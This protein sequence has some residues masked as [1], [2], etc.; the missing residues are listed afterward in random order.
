MN[1]LER[2][3]VLT[4]LIDRMREHESWCGETHIQKATY[5]LQTLLGV[6]ID[7]P[8]IMYKY[9]PF[10][11]DLRDEMVAMRADGHLGWEI[12]APYGPRYVSTPAA[13][14]M[15]AR[16]PQTLESYQSRIEFAAEKLGSKGV[17]ELEQLATALF[18]TVNPEALAKQ[19]G[20]MDR[21]QTLM[22]LK[23][24]IPYAAARQAIDEMDEII[25]AAKLQGLAALPALDAATAPLER[26][27]A[28]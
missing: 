6:P 21:P 15:Q 25:E 11:F 17:V 27:H 7:Q 28:A 16:H 12:Q 20:A 5:I 19:H 9:G 8:F 14:R 2:I 22:A 23:P 4:R 3:A 13:A 18:I 1:E 10:S 24:H 26:E